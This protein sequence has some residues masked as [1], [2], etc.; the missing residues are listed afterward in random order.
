MYTFLLALTRLLLSSFILS[1][2]F[3]IYQFFFFFV[4]LQENYFFLPLFFA[5]VQS[6]T[7][8]KMNS[9]PMDED[10]RL[11]SPP[12]CEAFLVDVHIIPL[13]ELYRY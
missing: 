1:Q 4:N 5:G 12:K 3:F 10:P 8:D 7:K 13:G 9:C 6:V 2:L 11:D